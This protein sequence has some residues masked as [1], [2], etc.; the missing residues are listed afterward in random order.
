[1]NFKGIIGQKEII[2][3]LKSSIESDRIGHAYMF[4]GPRGIGKKSVAREFAQMLLCQ[5]GGKD[6]NCGC[7]SCSMLEIG[8]NPD[9]FMIGQSADANISIEEIRKLQSDII[10]K[11]MY[12]KRKV[13]LIADSDRMTVQ[14]QNCLLK[15]LEEPPHYAV[16][17]LTTYNA[18]ALLET[19]RSRTQKCNFKKNTYDEISGLLQSRFGSN[20]GNIDFIASFSD[21][22]IGNALELAESE[23]FGQLRDNAMGI[24]FRLAQSGLEG[25]FDIYD[26]FE[27]NKNSID[28]ILDIMLLVYRDMLVSRTSGNEILLINSDKKDIILS[29][30]Q[31]FSML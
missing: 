9:F 25:V 30:A 15:I 19:I 18:N 6:N 11:P 21:G 13:Y 16:L 24:V 12:S 29:N 2:S 5:G 26:Y 3:S 17:L 31:E 28:N 4:I 1:M 22:V 23:E 8:S 20:L 7:P 14:A 27:A 10:I